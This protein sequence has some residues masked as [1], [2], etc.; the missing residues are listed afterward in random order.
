MSQIVIFGTGA[1]AEVA[2]FYFT[3]DSDHEVV[4][5]T[6]HRDR[7]DQEAIFGLP[8][9]PFEDVTRLYP[10]DRYGMFVAVGYNKVNQVRA[11]IYQEAKDLGYQL[12]TYVNSKIVSWGDT[13]I[14]DNCFIFE[15]QTI[16]PFVQIGNDTVLWSGNHV[17]HHSRIGDHCFITSHVVISGYTRIGDY[18]FLGVNATLRDDITIGRSNIIGAGAIIMKDTQ[19]NEVYVPQRTKPFH[20]TSDQVDL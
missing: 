8:V 11:R 1:F 16:Q 5:F 9:V 10:P 4:A 3:H 15:N 14:G 19:D 12:V 13:V 2:H 6:A 17:G 7:I 18:S 20:L